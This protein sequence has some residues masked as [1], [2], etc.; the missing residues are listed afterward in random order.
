MSSPAPLRSWRALAVSIALA[1]SAQ[2]ATE[3]FTIRPATEAT[4]KE[5]RIYNHGLTSNLQSSIGLTHTDVGAHFVALLQFDMTSLPQLTPANITNA[6]IRLHCN[7]KNVNNAVPMVAGDVTVTPIYTSWK[8][9]ATDPGNAP[10]GTYGAFFTGTATMILGQVAATQN[11]NAEGFVDFDVTNLVR[12]WAGIL[13]NNGVILQMSTSGGNVG[14]DDVDSNPAVANSGPALIIEADTTAPVVQP[15]ARAFVNANPATGLGAVPNLVSTV[16][17]TDDGGQAVT[18]TQSPT[19]NTQLALGDHTITFQVRDSLGNT[20]VA[21]TTLSVVFDRPAVAGAAT[22]TDAVTGTV[23]NTVQLPANYSLP[24]GAKFSAFFNPAIS[25]SR[26]LAARVTLANGSKKFD[27]IYFESWNGTQ[28]LLA[29]AGSEAFDGST[30]KTFLDPVV[31]PTGK[32]AFAAKVQ[33]GGL[34]GAE[35]EGVWTN[36]FGSGL[37]LALLEGS[38]ING[39]V[40][41][42]NQP[43]LKAV[44]SLSLR[45]NELLALVQLATGKAGVTG[46]NDTALIRIDKEGQA[47][48]VVREGAGLTIGTAS[49]V[50]TIS[51]LSPALGSNGQGRW[52]GDAATMVKVTLADGRVAL[53]SIDETGSADPLLVSNNTAAEIGLSAKWKTFGLPAVDGFGDNYAVLATLSPGTGVTTAND[54]AIVFTDGTTFTNVAQENEDAPVTGAPATLPKFATF[55][56]P[57]VNDAGKVAFMATLKGAGV[58]GANKTGLWS[59]TPANLALTAR[60]G[61]IATIADGTTPAT[62]PIWS[63]FVN[64][65]LPDGTESGLVFVAKLSGTGSTPKNNL[66]LWA[67]DSTGLVRELLRT[68]A[69]NLNPASAT[70]KLTNITLLTSAPGSYGVARSYNAT[71]SLVVLATFDDKSQALLRVDVP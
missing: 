51:V 26:D 39:L 18:I 59:G 14:L 62:G 58:S 3:T 60:L 40:S 1:T 31:S 32:I 68:G 5:A 52:H 22:V 55:F 10:L 25:D 17:A 15:I 28:S 63:S 21:T 36:L 6:K 34:S 27:G 19:A 53:L 23:P 7:G 50:K 30:F 29:V 4:S 54:Q 13:P 35:D 11:V 47:S 44:T 33:G 24:V 37:E 43:V 45:D 42:F 41:G 8:E 56:D 61:S 48:F 64:Y 38:P 70:S 69:E 71:G 46:S 12:Q 16:S 66:G 65:A 57:A 49:T 2:A 20:T 9:L 67:V